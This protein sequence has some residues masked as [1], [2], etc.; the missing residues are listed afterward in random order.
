M[1][2]ALLIVTLKILLKRRTD[3]QSPTAKHSLIAF[4]VLAITVM[5]AQEK[6]MSFAV[7][8]NKSQIGT[9]DIVRSQ[10]N[11]NTVFDLFAEI[12][13]R[14]IFRY[15]IVGIERTV[16][17]NGKLSYSSIMRICNNKVKVNKELTKK[18]EYYLL[19]DGKKTSKINING[20][21]RNLVTLYYSEPK[22]VTEVYCDN[23]QSMGKVVRLK[24]HI[25]KVILPDGNY[26]VFYYKNNRCERVK[27]FNLLYKVELISI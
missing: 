5:N 4:L 11:M 2:L 25:Y 16:F 10:Q 27:V 22:N 19:K 7:W 24:D 3:R 13:T 23:Q 8:K 12:N 6:K 14:F 9:I 18:N 15:N 21:E 17:K 1:L 20:I 26:S